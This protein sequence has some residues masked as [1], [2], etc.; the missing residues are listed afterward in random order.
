M[1][2]SKQL[3]KE[4]MAKYIDVEKYVQTTKQALKESMDECSKD[5]ADGVLCALH[6]AEQIAKNTD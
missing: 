2:S 4:N 3:I 1:K 6:I 5:F